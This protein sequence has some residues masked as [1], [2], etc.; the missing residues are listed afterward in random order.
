MKPFQ[1]DLESVDW[2]KDSVSC[3]V[4]WCWVE[5]SSAEIKGSA[6]IVEAGYGVEMLSKENMFSFFEHESVYMLYNINRWPQIYI[7]KVLRFALVI[8]WIE[9]RTDCYLSIPSYLG[10]LMPFPC[11]WSDHSF[12]MLRSG[13]MARK[14]YAFWYH[15]FLI[16]TRISFQ[17]SR[18]LPLATTLQFCCIL[19]DLADLH[20]VSGVSWLLLLLIFLNEICCTA[21]L[22]HSL[23]PHHCR[24]MPFLPSAERKHCVHSAY[25]TWLSSLTHSSP[26]CMQWKG[27]STLPLWGERTWEQGWGIF[28]CGIMSLT[29]KV[30]L[31]PPWTL[32]CD[33]S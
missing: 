31:H 2:I 17:T 33:Q 12:R 25:F 13:H 26:V 14:T 15:S 18:K 24:I 21:R 3:Y 5:I 19:I 10:Y 7:C 4:C 22:K 8:R 20:I 30:T 6:W 29:M 16:R 27:F 11:L 28:L 32:P 23:S 9:L 1:G